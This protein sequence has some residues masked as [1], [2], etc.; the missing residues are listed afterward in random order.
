MLKFIVNYGAYNK[1]WM[2]YETGVWEPNTLKVIEKILSPDKVYVDIGAWIG[3]TVL[4]AT[5]FC[6]KSYAIEPDPVAYA[7]LIKNVNLNPK[8]DIECHNLMIGDK[9]GKGS[10]LSYTQYGDSMSVIEGAPTHEGRPLCSEVES[11]TLETFLNN[12]PEKISDIGLIKMDIEGGE[13]I[14][15]K[16]AYDFIKQ[17]MPNIYISLHPCWFGIGDEFNENVEI[18]LDFIKIY[19]N[20]YINGLQK[21]SEEGIRDYLNVKLYGLDLLLT[22]NAG[23]YD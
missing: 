5:N 12:I 13:V 14:V 20:A 3:P 19:G 11:L 6:K 22:N 23:A 17:T 10:L 1:F 16:N 18:I 4:Y 21:M 9:D 8:L 2:E 15:F 7:E